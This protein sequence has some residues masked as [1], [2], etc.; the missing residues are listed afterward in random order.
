MDESGLALVM[1]CG[2]RSICIFVVVQ[3]HAEYTRHSPLNNYYT[4]GNICLSTPL[5]YPSP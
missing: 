4:H 1:H 5:A 2:I 3:Q